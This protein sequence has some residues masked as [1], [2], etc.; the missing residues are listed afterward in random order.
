M[1]LTNIDFYQV[2]QLSCRCSL[3]KQP[4]FFACNR[5]FIIFIIALF[6]PLPY[7]K[8]GLRLVKISNGT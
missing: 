8:L 3:I 7:R 5:L 2:L 6:L 1:L 4:Y